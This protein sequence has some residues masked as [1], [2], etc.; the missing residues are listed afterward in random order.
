[1]ADKY[2]PAI[3]RRKVGTYPAS[4][5]SGG[6]YFYD[7][8]L[9]YR[10]WIHPEAGGRDVHGGEDYF[11]AFATYQEALGFCKK[12]KGAEPPLVL[13]FQK[14]HINEPKPGIFEHIRKQR[15]AE[16]QPNWLEGSKRN[17]GSIGQFLTGYGR[18]S[19]SK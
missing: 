9:E 2:P 5:K 6:G 7:D 1:M 12:T 4:A 18:R 16:W 3:N 13:V 10:V 11:Y 8:V 15:I 14:E 17:Q 19:A